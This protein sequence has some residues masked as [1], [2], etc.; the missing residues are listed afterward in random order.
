M[1]LSTPIIFLALTRVGLSFVVTTYPDPDCQGEYSARL[2]VWD[3]S[4]AWKK[5]ISSVRIE[6]YGGHGQS[7]SF[8]P[9]D[10]CVGLDG[11]VDYLA[12]GGRKA[13]PFVK[14]NCISFSFPVQS[15]G[16]IN[17]V[18]TLVS[19]ASANS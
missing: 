6:K 11:S 8:Y 14:G 17:R 13:Y 4:C 12:D 16:S 2:N 18:R 19:L 7:A 9:D 10:I 1:R 3:D 5:N 15:I